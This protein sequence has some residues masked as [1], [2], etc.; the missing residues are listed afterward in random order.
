MKYTSIF[1][2]TL[3]LTLIL[4]M[5]FTSCDDMLDTETN[6]DWDTSYVWTVSSLSEGILDKAYVDMPDM[7]D[8]YGSN[9]LDAATDNAFTNAYSSNIHA[10]S[11]GEMTSKN[12]PLAIWGTCYKNFQ[13]IHL[14]MENGLTDRVNYIKNDLEKDKEYKTRLLGEAYFLRAYWGWR[15]LQVYGG[16]TDDG[17]ALGYPIVTRFV[18][19][20]SLMNEN[21]ARNSYEECAQQIMNDCD[22]AY[23]LLPLAYSGSDVVTGITDLGR[24]SGLAAL[25]LKTQVALYAAS[26][27]YQPDEI[28]KIN[29]M[30]DYTIEDETAYKAKWERAALI[31]NTCMNTTGFGNVYGLKATDLADAKAS[32]PTEFIYRRYYNNKSL[33]TRQFPPYYLGYARTVPS[34]NL[35]DAYPAKNGFPISDPRSEYDS[36]NPYLNRDN[37]FNLTVYHHGEIYGGTGIMIDITDNGAFGMR[38]SSLNSQTGYYLAKGISKT[39]NM[40]DVSVNK[41]AVHYFPIFRKMQVFL[42][43]AEAANEAWGPKGV[44]DGVSSTAYDIIKDVRKVSGGITST[45]YLDEMAADKDAFRTLIHNERRIELAFESSRYWDLRRWLD[46]LNKPVYGVSVSQDES[47]NYVYDYKEVEKRNYNDIK[48]YYAPIPT[49]ELLKMSNC[50]NNLGWNK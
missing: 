39:Q 34:Q 47:F 42:A 20:D 8:F 13:Y 46:V 37:R 43:F 29:A 35:V 44:G 9:Y 48:Y 14:F 3:V 4:G 40:L 1:I 15:L 7:P 33:E 2:R 6:N 18:E 16:K 24:A 5:T 28:V 41:N 23:I 27:A 17:E 49:E 50:K 25:A 38:Y 21:L 32:T 26:P 10:L 45:T 19:Q 11:S 22:S 36:Q 12:N 31:A 30:G